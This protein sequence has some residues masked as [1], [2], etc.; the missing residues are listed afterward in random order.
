MSLER[1][2]ERA[3]L[4][5]RQ[6]AL[7][8]KTKAERVFEWAMA[9]FATWCVGFLML[10][11]LLVSLGVIH[12]VASPLVVVLCMLLLTMGGAFILI[13]SVAR[14]I[15]AHEVQQ[16]K[17]YLSQFRNMSAVA[18]L[19]SSTSGGGGYSNYKKNTAVMTGKQFAAQVKASAAEASAG[20]NSST[21]VTQATNM[22]RSG[23]R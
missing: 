20:K 15:A 8:A 4:A 13:R 21:A 23:R 5:E 22:M 9:A 7:L 14:K 11:G 18:P 17:I 10:K 16:S 12:T 6:V 1:A 3:R 2:E 19:R